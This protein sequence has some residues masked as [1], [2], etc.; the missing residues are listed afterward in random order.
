MVVKFNILVALW[1][2]LDMLLPHLESKCKARDVAI[3]RDEQT[4]LVNFLVGLNDGFDQVRCQIMLME[5]L[6]S[7]YKAY[8]MIVQV[9]DEKLLNESIYT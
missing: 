7:M 1:D 5:P 8:S 9:E 3:E 2:K 6:P 4:R